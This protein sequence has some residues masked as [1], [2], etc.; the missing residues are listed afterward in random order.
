MK[1]RGLLKES[2][3]GALKRGGKD[4]QTD[5]FRKEEREPITVSTAKHQ[6][7]THHGEEEAINGNHGMGYTVGEEIKLL[8]PCSHNLKKKFLT[9]F[10][11]Q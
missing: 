1:A 11:H 3:Q 7:T 9:F 4:R 6:N 2:F 8:W 5:E 10:C